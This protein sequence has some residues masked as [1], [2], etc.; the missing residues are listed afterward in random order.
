M[1]TIFF[2]PGWVMVEAVYCLK[3][4]MNEKVVPEVLCSKIFVSIFFNFTGTKGWQRW[5]RRYGEYHF[6][7]WIS[8]LYTSCSFTKQL[9]A[10]CWSN[11]VLQQACHVTSVCFLVVTWKISL[12]LPF[13]CLCAC[14][15]FR[16]SQVEMELDSRVHQAHLD[17]QEKSSTGHLAT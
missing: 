6:L 4:S 17:H 10:R 3:L 12:D 2:W 15:G 14:C 11:G 16:V 13:C 1:K 5:Q 8:A 7:T 9:T